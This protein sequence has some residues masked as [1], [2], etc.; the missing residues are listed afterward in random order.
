MDMA[1]VMFAH[2]ELFRLSITGEKTL[3]QGKS[4]LRYNNTKNTG[5]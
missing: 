5:E 4:V 3:L 1:P 2:L